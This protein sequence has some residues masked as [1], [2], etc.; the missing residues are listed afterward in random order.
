MHFSHSLSI[1]KSCKKNSGVCAKLQPLT[2]NVSVSIKNRGLGFWIVI[3]H[4]LSTIR[5]ADLILVLEEGE[6]VEVGSWDELLARGG[7]FAALHAAQFEP[8]SPVTA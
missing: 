7:T 4:R 1:L 5:D 8:G 3:A 6:L 2:V